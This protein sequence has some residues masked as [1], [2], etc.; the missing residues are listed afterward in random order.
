MAAL[1]T[2]R[3]FTVEEYHQMAQAGIFSEDDRVELIKGEV[4]EMTPIGSSHAACVKRLN[5]LFSQRVGDRALISIQDPI[6]IDPHSEPQ[7]DVALLQ[8]RQDYYAS[9]HPNPKDILL[10]IEV[11]DTSANY[12]RDVKIPIYAQAG[13]VEVWLIDLAKTCVEV[14]R[15]PTS[16][17]YE[18]V[19]IVRRGERLTPQAFPQLEVTADEILG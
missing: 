8:L 17:G 12:D 16:Q 2:R 9:T 6:R 14:Y 1:L 18:R 15:E 4:V 11:A 10:V 3:R 13:I 7:P 19:Q 5:Q